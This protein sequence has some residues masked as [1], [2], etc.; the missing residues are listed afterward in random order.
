MIDDVA[1][2]ERRRSKAAGRGRR[3]D[4]CGVV[5][6]Y[7]S[8]APDDRAYGCEAAGR[9]EELPGRIHL[10]RADGDVEGGADDR[11]GGIGDP[12]AR[13]HLR[14]TVAAGPEGRHV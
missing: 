5:D 11:V 7:A 13:Q 14:R 6:E 9:V 3:D 4:P 1:T 8:S 2:V 12:I 10:E